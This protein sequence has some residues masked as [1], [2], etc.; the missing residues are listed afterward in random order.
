PERA[1]QQR[2]SERAEKMHPRRFH[3][4]ARGHRVSSVSP[5][6]RLSSVFMEPVE[7][8]VLLSTYAVTTTA[9]SGA[10]SLRQAIL[11]A[12]KTIAEDTI[13]F[14]I[15]SG[16]KTISPKTALPAIAQP[17]LLD[18]T[19]QP[20]FAGKPLIELSGASAGG[21][22]GIKLT[23]TGITVKGL[24]INRFAGSGIFIYGKGGN[25]ITGNWIGVDKTGSAAAPNGS[26]GVFVQSPHNIIGGTSA[27]DRN[28]ISG[29]ANA[30]VFFYLAA[31]S[32]NQILGN[33]IGTDATRGKPLANHNG[34]QINGA[35]REII[36][37][38]APGSRNVISANQ[39]DSVL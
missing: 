12:N 17:T 21:A 38:T 5:V 10:G 15:G 30:G 4:P 28:V 18:A 20:G 16:A 37:G 36:G 11:D 27:A 1:W 13:K 32:D 7:S 3:R 19:T 22:E 26:S 31:G 34:V 23:G 14:A 39:R 25:R 9:D 29:N 2:L 8:R 6:S 24:V 35:A 33:Y